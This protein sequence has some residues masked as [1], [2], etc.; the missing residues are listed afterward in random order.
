MSR[1]LVALL[2][3]ALVLGACA[4]DEELP[5]PDEEPVEEPDEPEEPEDEPDEPEDEPDE[6]E[7]DDR[8]RSPLTGMPV[9]PELLELPLL[10]AKIEN[11]PQSRPQSG[12]EVADIVYEELV[13]GGVT[14]F[15][16]IFHSELPERAGPIRSARPVDT[17]LMS[18]YGRAGFAYS[19]ARPEVRGMLAQTPS[20]TITE[21]GAGFFRD[22]S[23]RAPHNLYLDATATHAA[24]VAREADPVGDV[25]W[26]F[27]DEPPPGALACTT[28]GAAVRAPAADRP[29][30]IP[31]TTTPTP[32][33]ARSGG[34]VGTPVAG[35]GASPG[36]PA[37]ECEEPGT[38]LDVQM[39]ISFTTGWEYDED[40]GL[41]RRLQNGQPF[42]VTGP[43]QIGAANVVVLAT[44]HYVGA[45]GYP[46]TD[47]VTAD[48]PAVVL[49]DGNR[50]DVRWSKPSV[51]A[52]IVLST[53][54]DEPFAL[55]PGPTWVLLP[56]ESALP[57]PPD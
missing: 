21:G 27:D 12:L 20:L 28:A 17:Q 16:V 29:H 49:R 33:G 3:A 18:G 1:L 38:S 2:A 8:P 55:K 50:Y 43:D 53:G 4:G 40:T 13:E 24:I 23:R 56:R 5:E 44:R 41:Y 15:F 32:G 14:R 6:P 7:E 48:A 54:D 39:S 57:P 46:E 51:D 10:Q 11:S 47:I 34:E 31:L 45:S 19:G 26:V 22:S 42:T 25:G 30:L 36:T 9:D 52:P 37:G 35:A